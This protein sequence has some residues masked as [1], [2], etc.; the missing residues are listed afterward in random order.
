MD[1]SAED[2]KHQHVFSV[3]KDDTAGHLPE[4]P[5]HDIMYK[6]AQESMFFNNPPEQW[7]A[8]SFHLLKGMQQTTTLQDVGMSP[9]LRHFSGQE[10][11]LMNVNLKMASICY[12]HS[13]KLLHDIA[14]CF[15]DFKDYTNRV[16][17]TIKT[18]A[19]EVATKIVN[20]RTS[21][22]MMLGSLSNLHEST[23]N[24]N[25]S[26]DDTGQLE[27]YNE[28]PETKIVLNAQLET[29][30]IVIP[31]MAS[32]SEVFVAHL[33]TISINNQ[34]K[35]KMEDEESER[36][37]IYHERLTVEA[38]DMNLYV[39]DID[40]PKSKSD[41]SMDQSTV[42]KSV[43][44][45][46]E[47]GVPIM[48]DTTV[49]IVIEL[50]HTNVLNKQEME[51]VYLGEETERKS[52]ENVAA[53]QNVV[54]IMAKI[55]TPIKLELSKGVYEQVLETVDNLTYD[56][57]TDLKSPSYL[58][59]SS[60]FASLQ[61][62]KE[63]LPEI[64]EDATDSSEASPPKSDS[65]LETAGMITKISFEVP[66]FNVVLKGDFDEGEKGLVDLKLHNF[67]VDFEKSNSY[68]TSIEIQLQSLTMQDLLASTDSEHKFLLISR[69]AKTDDKDRLKP[70]LFLSHSCPDSTILMP[71]AMLPSSLPASFHDNISHVTK[72]SASD[73]GGHTAFQSSTTQGH[74][75]VTG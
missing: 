3:G 24:S 73:I 17:T 67:S 59:A 48:H 58:S 45:Q 1:V 10:E 71:T 32:S 62:V 69:M 2:I 42:N 49:E 40:N 34:S 9:R 23:F 55:S 13:P 39:A 51:T 18:A 11:K 57:K 43:Y 19:S 64:P 33:G 47:C 5:L 20:K 54:E 14:E 56:E 22:S 4:M 60:S 75:K 37:V 46:S 12:V 44:G 53:S 21:D 61:K 66:L 30:V 27:N 38:R 29:P 68:S 50:G 25:L 16:A 15:A 35:E 52:P 36:S 70:R 7:E 6:T 41:K 63:T 72:P 8:F 31:R 28:E 65:Q 74:R 26:L